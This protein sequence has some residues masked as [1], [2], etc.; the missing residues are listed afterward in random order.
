MASGSGQASRPIGVVRVW[1]SCWD[2][3]SPLLASFSLCHSPVLPG[4]M[5][6]P[7]PLPYLFPSCL[8][9]QLDRAAALEVRAIG[10]MFPGWKGAWSRE[11]LAKSMIPKQPGQLAPS[12]AQVS[13]EL[14]WLAMEV[15]SQD[16]C[17]LQ[18]LLSHPCPH[19]STS[20][21]RV[22]GASIL[23]LP[24][25]VGRDAVRYVALVTSG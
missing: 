5:W 9:P 3:R 17:N 6:R 19:P 18:G 10:A 7:P 11:A 24:E 16:L 23:T 8:F 2:S 15:L 25:G 22:S 12:F 21:H 13:P 14:P 1:R 20:S 4:H